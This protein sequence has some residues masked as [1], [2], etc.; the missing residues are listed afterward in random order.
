MKHII[1]IILGLLCLVGIYFFVQYNSQPLSFSLQSPS[2]TPSPSRI[3][4]QGKTQKMLFVPYWGLTAQKLPTDYDQIIYFGVTP[5]TQGINTQED[6][7]K[8]L[9]LFAKRAGDAKT[10]LAIRMIDPTINVKVLQDK[11]MQNAIITDSLEIAQKYNFSGIVLD[12]EYNA[13]AFDSV[14]T[15]INTFSTNF[16]KAVHEGHMAYYQSLYGD[17]FYRLRPY[18]V[19]TLAKHADGII[20]MAYDFHKANGDAG[21]NFP[22]SG[23]EGYDLKS[24]IEDFGKKMPTDKMAV[25]FGLYGYDWQV[26][27]EGHSQGPAIPLSLLQIQQKFLTSCSFA[28]CKVKRDNTSSETEVI[29]T[30]GNKNKHTVWFEDA[31]SV[32]AKEAYLK[33]Q[34][35]NATALWAWSYF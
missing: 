22:L 28:E 32:A 2:L 24:M 33:S 16:A 11:K 4:V 10:L 31:Q 3:I 12:F 5:N 20:I 15:S 30:D 21:P 29:Y 25:A 19:G 26:D 27:K 35:I 6:G 9:S 1:A 18:D 17:T 34:G 7:Y 13:L 14:I 8:D 23:N